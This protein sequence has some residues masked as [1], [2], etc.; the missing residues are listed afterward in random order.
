M[1]SRGSTLNVFAQATLVSR[2]FEAVGFPRDDRYRRL[3]AGLTGRI[4]ER[5]GA[6]PRRTLTVCAENLTDESYMEVLGFRAPGV[7]FLAGLQATY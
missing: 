3:D 6:F 1:S 2:Q 7:N 5:R 4:A